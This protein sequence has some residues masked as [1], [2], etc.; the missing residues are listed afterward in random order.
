M[1]CEL[2]WSRVEDSVR[3]F[4]CACD[5]RV[6]FENTR[7]LSCQRELG[8][9]PDELVVAALAP[10][11]GRAVT[12]AFG[13]YRKCENYAEHGVCNWLVPEAEMSTLCQACRLNRVIPDLSNPENHR[14]WAEVE[15]AKRQLVYG[16]IR[17]RLP[18]VAKADD[19]ALGV[20]FDIKAETDGERVLT[21]H[22]DGLITLNL[23]EADAATREKIR[24]SMNERYR[25]LLGHFR[26]EIGHYYFRVLVENGGPIDDF[27]SVFGDERADYAEALK[28]HYGKT[29]RVPN[30]AFVSAYAEA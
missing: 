21:G 18:L 27:R 5:A 12:T 22:A 14:L 11:E 6:F 20:A 16:L 26:H 19:D 30:D 1:A 2:L 9:L 28:A 25:T 7:C 17:L 8:F 24:E 4:E 10:G 13:A 3:S 29:A 23:G 15:H